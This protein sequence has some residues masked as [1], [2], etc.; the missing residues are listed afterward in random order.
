MLRNVP[1]SSTRIPRIMNIATITAP[2][3]PPKL[4]CRLSISPAGTI[5]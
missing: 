3:I 4:S 2:P 1:N 5:R